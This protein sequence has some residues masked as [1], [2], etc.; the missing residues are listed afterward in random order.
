MGWGHISKPRF[1]CEDR[2]QH[3]INHRGGKRYGDMCRQS[4]THGLAL[5][6]GPNSQPLKQLPGLLAPFCNEV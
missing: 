3:F 4:R 6:R 2:L 5:P 1:Q